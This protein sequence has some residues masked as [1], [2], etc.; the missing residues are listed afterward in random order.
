M[1]RFITIHLLSALPWSNLNRD[2][3][4][5]PKSLSQGGVERGML[6]SQSLKRAA[7]VAFEEY[8]EA[9]DKSVRSSRGH[10]E[11]IAAEAVKIA[12]G[13]GKT[14]DEKKAVS[15]ANRLVKLLVAKEKEPKKKKGADDQEETVAAPDAKDSSVWLSAAEVLQ[16][17]GAVA[18]GQTEI[19]DELGAGRKT[20]SLSIAAFG[21]MFANASDRS[22]EAAVAVSPATMTHAMQI[23]TDYF[24]TADDLAEGGASFLSTANYTNGVYYR[25]VTIDPRQLRRSWSGIDAEGA[26]VLVEGLIRQLVLAL[27]TGKL[28]STN[29]HTPP[30]IALVEEQERRQAYNYETPVRPT[31]SVGGFAAG[32]IERLSQ[33]RSAALDFDPTSLG[34]SYIAGTMLGEIGEDLFAGVDRVNLPELVS[35]VTKSVLEA[36]R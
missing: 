22:T 34:T 7:R 24:T 31:A 9:S 17:A 28:N 36:A 10:A 25:S 20:H 29:A 15:E 4:G 3:A 16:L 19:P 18:A 2:D 13:E 12:A 5:L 35:R 1:T 27:P 32:S 23:A 6:S 26:E 33:M 30:V 8:L 21:R 11:V 14:L